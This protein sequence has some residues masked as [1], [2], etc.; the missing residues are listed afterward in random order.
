[1]RLIQFGKMHVYEFE[2]HWSDLPAYL[3]FEINLLNIGDDINT[4]VGVV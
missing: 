4:A 1:M 3:G 2:Y